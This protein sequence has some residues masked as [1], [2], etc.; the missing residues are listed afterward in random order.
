MIRVEMAESLMELVCNNCSLV[1]K[2]TKAE[3]R[4]AAKRGRIKVYCSRKCAS[5]NPEHLERLRKYGKPNIKNLI[6]GNRRD[7]FTPFR[8]HFRRIHNR[9]KECTITLQDLKDI[10]ENQDGKCGFKARFAVRKMRRRF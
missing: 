6:A 2:R 9:G 8:P 7:E 3:I 1:F 10:W 4:R 5:C